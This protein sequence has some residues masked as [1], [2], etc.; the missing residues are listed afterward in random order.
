M[1]ISPKEAGGKFDRELVRTDSADYAFGIVTVVYGQ[2][3][4][5]GHAVRKRPARKMP[6][7]DKMGK[8]GLLSVRFQT[9]RIRFYGQMLRKA[10]FVR[11]ICMRF[12]LDQLCSTVFKKCRTNSI[13]NRPPSFG[14]SFISSKKRDFFPS[15]LFFFSQKIPTDEFRLIRHFIKNVDAFTI[16]AFSHLNRKNAILNVM[17]DVMLKT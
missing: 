2:I 3:D 1:E 4:E 15:S 6:I 13:E 14:I 7:T 5:K 16:I 12:C 11:K 10:A 17:L 9:F 8:N